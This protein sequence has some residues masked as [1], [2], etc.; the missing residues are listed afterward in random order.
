MGADRLDTLNR[1]NHRVDPVGR[2]HLLA[3]PPWV[4]G[5]RNNRR[6]CLDLRPRCTLGC[7]LGFRLGI[8]AFGI[9]CV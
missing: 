4:D 6:N 2:G 5:S 8:G 7:E 1:P 3:V 9:P